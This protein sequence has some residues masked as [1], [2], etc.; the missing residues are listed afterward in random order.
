M[1]DTQNSPQQSL[2][3]N[4]SGRINIPSRV[5]PVLENNG[6]KFDAWLLRP[7]QTTQSDKKAIENFRKSVHSHPGSQSITSEVK[8]GLD[9]LGGALEKLDRDGKS[10]KIVDNKQQSMEELVSVLEHAL[11]MAK[12]PLAK[13]GEVIRYTREQLENIQNPHRA[14]ERELAQ[15]VEAKSP[16]NGEL[17]K[18]RTDRKELAVG[19]FHRVYGRFYVAGVIYKHQLRA[20]DADFAHLLA[21]YKVAPQLPTKQEANDAALAKFSSVEEVIRLASAATRRKFSAA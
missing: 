6:L 5:E 20:M 3:R 19:F 14:L 10:R 21:Q 16:P 18:T 11:S 4:D 7:A 9:K 17:Y 2:R 1:I 15:L 12:S 8:K 13:S